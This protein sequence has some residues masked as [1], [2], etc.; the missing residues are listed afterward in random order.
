MSSEKYIGLDAQDC[1]HYAD[2]VLLTFKMF[3]VCKDFFSWRLCG[4]GC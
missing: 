2:P 1:S 3:F 4:L